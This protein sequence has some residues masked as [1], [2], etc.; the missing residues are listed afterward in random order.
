MPRSPHRVHPYIPNSAPAS[1]EK[2]LRTV[3]VETV[4]ELYDAIPENLKLDRLLELPEAA[5]SE[6]DLKRHMRTLLNKNV[7][8]TD[9]LS[10]LGGGCWQHDVPAVCDEINSRAEFLTAYGGDTYADLG[11]YQAIFEFQSM[12]GE[13]VGMEMV[14]APV[15]D[16]SAAITSGL[17]MA[18]RVSGRRRTLIT[19]TLA[20]DKRSHLANTAGPWLDAEYLSIDDATGLVDLDDLRS[21]IGDDVSAVYVEVPSYFG[22]IEPDMEA[23]AAIVHSVGSLLVVGVDAISLGVL[24]APAEYGADIVVG[25][26]Q[27]LGV[28]MMYSGG[29]CGFIASRDEPEIVAEY[30]YLMVSIAPARNGR[31]WGFGW[32]S[33]ERTSYDLRESSP[34]YTG[35]TQWL[36]GITA[37]VYLSLLGPNGLREV[38]EGILQRSHYAVKKLGQL[39]GVKA[40]PFDAHFFKEFV[41]GFDETGKSVGEINTALRERGIFGGHDLSSE[42]P[43]LGQSALYCVTEIHTKADIDRLAETLAEVIR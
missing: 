12:I 18:A 32:S 42:F 34:D 26:A 3:G 7:P 41:V 6:L 8:A 11:K 24:E 20:P 40:N 29:L 10:F 28:H 43:E 16:W 25:E 31:E 27:A 37:A 38:G 39:N 21:R 2:M 23:I 4:E 5:V 36:W 13:L 15:Y 1:R 35:T 30:P 14:S 9:V 33:M 17:M 22:G 19:G